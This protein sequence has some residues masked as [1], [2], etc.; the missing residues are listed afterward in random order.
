MDLLVIS[1][2][3]CLPDAADKYEYPAVSGTSYQEAVKACQIPEK[4]LKNM[5]AFGLIRSFLDA[6]V[7]SSGFLLSS[8]SS[9]AAKMNNI[10]SLHNG[11]QEFLSR[12]NAGRA[13]LVYFDAICF[14]CLKNQEA[15]DN[16]NWDAQ[17][18]EAKKQLRL[19]AQLAAA[20]TLFAQSKILDQL[21]YNDKQ[22][23]VEM[24][25]AK[26]EQVSDLGIEG[27]HD[28]AA[29]ETM[30]CIMRNAQYK[31]IEEYLG[32]QDIHAAAYNAEHIISFAKN[33]IQ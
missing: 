16:M 29:I 4:T 9:P 31:P 32:A 20:E 26:Y 22:K 33:F 3:M 6:P 23:A 7:L 18:S 14:D 10:Y 21:N 11:I 8:S 5:S 30:A 15:I 1:P 28:P 25:F 17:V 12:K 27:F 19:I 2:G 24:L 13:L